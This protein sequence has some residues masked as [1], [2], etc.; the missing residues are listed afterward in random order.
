MMTVDECIEYCRESGVNVDQA[1]QELT[2]IYSALDH[3]ENALVDYV[4][5]LEKQG[6]TMGYGHQVVV[7]VRSAKVTLKD[8]FDGINP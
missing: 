3:S 1:L 5:R 8:V 6:A 4:E 7:I 2:L